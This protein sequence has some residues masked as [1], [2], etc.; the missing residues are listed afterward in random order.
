VNVRLIVVNR[1]SR[2]GLQRFMAKKS[3]K[4]ALRQEVADVFRRA[5]LDAAEQVFGAHG[6]ADAKMADIA[7]RAGLAAGTIYKHFESKEDV[8]GALL[9][10][11]GEGFD[12]ALD[13]HVTSAPGDVAERLL[14]L[15]RTVLTQ[16]EQRRATFRLL[17]DHASPDM[18]KFGGLTAE[19][20]HQN[21]VARFTEVFEEGVRSGVVCED[22]RPAEMAHIF[23]GALHGLIHEWLIHGAKTELASR[24]SLLVSALLR[25]VGARK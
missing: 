3:V 1:R 15:A 6:F 10:R 20:R 18:R 5:I 22:L 11:C 2:I 4:A 23:T 12:Q 9:E 17:L 16:C 13:E 21:Y 19:K 25:G 14:A 8:F 24:A 7:K